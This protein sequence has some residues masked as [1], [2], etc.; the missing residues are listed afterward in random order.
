[1]QSDRQVERQNLLTSRLHDSRGLHFGC[2]EEQAA[3]GDP[4]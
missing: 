4:F 3:E 2:A 1:M